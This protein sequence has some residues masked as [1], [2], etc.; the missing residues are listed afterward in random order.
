MSGCDAAGGTQ[1]LSFGVLKPGDL[2]QR[3]HETRYQPWQAFLSFR[4]R[5][6]AIRVTMQ[7]IEQFS[8][9]L[10]RGQITDERGLSR[11][12]AQSL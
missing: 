5:R 7:P 2:S 9:G 4:L 1:L 12:L 10:I 11:V 6:R 3:S 8:F